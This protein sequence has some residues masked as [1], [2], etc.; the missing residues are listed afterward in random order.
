MSTRA[1]VS[2]SLSSLELTVHSYHFTGH[3]VIERNARRGGGSSA[4]AQGHSPQVI[5]LGSPRRFAARAQMPEAV[6]SPM[7]VPLC[8]SFKNSLARYK[9][10]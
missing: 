3:G 9:Q 6:A 7:S 1:R 8:C 5:V 10:S 4:R 2:A